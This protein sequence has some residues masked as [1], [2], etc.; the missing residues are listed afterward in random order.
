MSC[1]KNDFTGRNLGFLH[2]SGTAISVV[3]AHITSLRTCFSHVAVVRSDS[4]LNHQL[5]QYVSYI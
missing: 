2:Q 5:A 4:I 3:D 1:L